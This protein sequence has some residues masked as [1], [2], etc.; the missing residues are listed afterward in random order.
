MAEA[1][2]S[3]KLARFVSH[4]TYGD[5]TNDQTYL[6]KTYFLDWLASA[7]AGQTERPIQ[8]ILEVVRGLGGRAQSTIIPDSSKTISLLAAF[9]NGA[10]SHMVEMD[11]LHR[12]SILHPGSA[13][14]S[15]VLATAE[16]Q[17]RSGK[18]LITSIAAGYEVAVRI[19]MAV[20]PSH[21]RYWH[22]TATCG[23]FGAA[24]GASRIF[25]LDEDKTTWAL[26]SAGTQAAGLWAFLLENA[27]S[28]QLHPG[29]AAMNGILAA[30]LAQKGFTGA[31]KILEGEKGFFQ[32]TS[33]DFD[34]SQCLK[35]L[36][37]VYLFE[38]NSLKY[39]ASCGHT[40]AA[41]DAVLSATGGRPMEAHL[42]KRVN[43]FVYP[44]AIDLLGKVMPE[45]PYM[46]KFSL[47]FCVATALRFG[48]AG[49]GDFTQSKIVDP[50][51]YDLIEKI[52]IQGDAELGRNYPAQWPARIE[53]KT[54]EGETLYGEVV[55]PKGDPENPLSE[56]ELSQKF[57][58]LTSGI[59]T[60]SR[61]RMVMDE[62]MNLEEVSDIGELHMALD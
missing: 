2:I 51:I 57:L 60:S 40:H 49:L 21:Y 42:I 24:A 37:S 33:V 3:R 58:D 27:M 35:E 26:G 14:M 52:K 32:A 45:T 23:T 18:E 59:L 7:F 62:V 47:P 29:K 25:G 30:L 22:T 43:L 12:Q 10:S 39:H 31:E 16:Q 28:K 11:D 5:L 9:V 34:E 17:H 38:R 56:E 46:A 44:Q 41:I 8:I 4:L 13:V 20:G 61:A 54:N 6:I 50:D 55:Y 53:V 1:S 36:G 48:S 15:A 19:A